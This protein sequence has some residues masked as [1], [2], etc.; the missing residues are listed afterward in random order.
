MILSKSGLRFDM[1][2]AEENAALAE[3]SVSILTEPE[4]KSALAAGAKEHLAT[5]E[6]K[7]AL[8]QNPLIKAAVDKTLT[9]AANE[10]LKDIKSKDYRSLSKPFAGEIICM[11]LALH[12]DEALVKAVFGRTRSAGIKRK[13]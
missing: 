7:N 11:G 10:A 5:E 3:A 4:R 8:G 12:E 6:I 2:K 13:T 9:L 1:T